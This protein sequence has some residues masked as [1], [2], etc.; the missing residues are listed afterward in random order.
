[1]ASVTARADLKGEKTVVAQQSL[2]A[3]TPGW[4][5]G[6]Q[7][8]VVVLGD[9]ILDGW[10]CGPSTRLSREAPVP[11]VEVAERIDGP[12]G[13]ANTAVNLAALGAQTWL[14]SVTGGD[15][16][17]TTVR[18]ELAR[19]G[20]QTDTMLVEAGRRTVAKRRVVAGDQLVARFDEGGGQP[21]QPCTAKALAGVLR[22]VVA[23]CDAVVIGDYGTG[24]L[25][26][27][28]RAELVRLRSQ[29]PLLVV[30]AHELGGWEPLRPDLVTPN[31][32]EAG[33]LLGADLPPAPEQRLA[34]IDR[35][36]A[37]LSNKTGAGAVVVTLDR[38]GAVLLAPGQPVHRT[39]ARPAPQNR[40]CGAGDTFAAALTLAA[41]GGMPL[42]TAVEFAQAAA[43]VVVSR[44]G[45]TVCTTSQLSTRL[46]D[47]RSAALSAEEL[48]VMV[49]EH[50]ACGRRVV[51]TNGCFDVLHRG[52][53]AY[54]NQA[55]R[56]GEV[57]VV[58]VNDDE[59]VARL[60]GPGRPVN[61]V[62]DR[63]SVL[64]ALSCVDH[65]TTFGADTAVELLDLLRPDVYAKGG[66]YT[67]EMLSET[68]TVRGY[69]GSVHILDYVPDQSTSAVIERIRG[70]AK[71]G[72][73]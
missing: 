41:A 53:I 63:A 17:G 35:R 3:G 13:A 36:R 64:A 46:G 9:A 8:R 50:R 22:E 5:A 70:G 71:L 1:V 66:D 38:D 33:R 2:T 24:I 15:A 67:P 39:W 18:R 58:A 62:T 40:A 19:A 44:P 16:D 21:L 65:V 26:A 25:G 72:G 14:V 73:A 54:L 34:E 56:L 55:K 45:T 27:A 47:F 49:D 52:H 28:V 20:V 42:T 51:F 60:K 32:D 30:D 12:G 69:G 48:T 59:S 31:A 43:D 6:R 7:P 4:L 29:I 11:I 57:L 23:Q 61:P 10:L 37:D 68:P